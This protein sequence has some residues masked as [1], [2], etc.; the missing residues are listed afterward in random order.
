MKGSNLATQAATGGGGGDGAAAFS[1]SGFLEE[2]RLHSSIKPF[3]IPTAR[4]PR[5]SWRLKPIQDKAVTLLLNCGSVNRSL[6]A[7][8]LIT[9]HIFT[10]LSREPVAN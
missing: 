8:P 10:V 3:S 6:T 9:S 4:N 1:F 2:E 7:L 5:L